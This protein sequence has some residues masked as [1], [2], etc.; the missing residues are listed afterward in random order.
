V[1]RIEVSET[2][3]DLLTKLSVDPLTARLE[4]AAH[5]M[6]AA[7]PNAVPTGKTIPVCR[8]VMP[9]PAFIDLAAKAQMLVGQ[10]KAQGIIK[11]IQD[12]GGSGRPH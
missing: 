11:D 10:L 4:F 8:V 2:F 12:P 3:A 5:R 6:D 7:Q 1:D 9:F